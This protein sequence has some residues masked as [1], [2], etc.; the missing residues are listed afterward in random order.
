MEGGI[1]FAG[2]VAVAALKRIVAVR[3]QTMLFSQVFDSHISLLLA[4]NL[5][6]LL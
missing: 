5:L 1:E 6:C 3:M 4:G 2:M